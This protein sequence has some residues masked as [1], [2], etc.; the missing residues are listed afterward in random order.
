M[1]TARAERVDQRKAFKQVGAQHGVSK[2]KQGK[3][4]VHWGPGS[5]KVT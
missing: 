5:T 4:D 1:G 2:P 3:E